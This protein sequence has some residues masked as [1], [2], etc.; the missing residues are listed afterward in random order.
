MS[1][2]QKLCSNCEHWR[3]NNEDDSGECRVNPPTVLKVNDCPTALFPVTGADDW[4]GWHLAK[5]AHAAEA[6]RPEFNRALESIMQDGKAAGSAGKPM[7]NPHKGQAAE[8]WK[9]GWLHG[10]S[11]FEKSGNP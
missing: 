5:V 9:A 7:D 6:E 4:C 3:K 11:A 10:R 1:E 2:R 8:A